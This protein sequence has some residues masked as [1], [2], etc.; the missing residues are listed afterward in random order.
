MLKREGVSQAIGRN[1][2]EMLKKNITR[3][4]SSK[5]HCRIL[6]KPI[7]YQNHESNQKQEYFKLDKRKIQK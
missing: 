5:W 7:V 1:H 2:E 6:V 3:L 4:D